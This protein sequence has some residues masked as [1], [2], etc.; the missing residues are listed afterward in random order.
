MRAL[1]LEPF[2]GISGNM[3]LGALLAAGVLF[4]YLKHAF[5]KMR[6]GD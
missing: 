4:E 3:L 2:A 5:A 1:Y 6:V